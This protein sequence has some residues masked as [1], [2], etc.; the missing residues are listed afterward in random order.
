MIVH[1]K[2]QKDYKIEKGDLVKLRSGSPLMTVQMVTCRGIKV[3]WFNDNE[4]I[5]DY[6]NI[7]QLVAFSSTTENQNDW[8]NK[9][10]L[11]K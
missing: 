10:I 9:N 3:S 11:D 1:L 4:S 8:L 7:E 2:D 6:F 5:H